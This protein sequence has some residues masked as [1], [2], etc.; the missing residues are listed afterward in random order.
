LL[1]KR[2][3]ALLKRRAQA[4][5]FDAAGM[6]DLLDQ[7]ER[8]ALEDH[9]GFRGQWD[10]HRRFQIEQLRRLGLQTECSL[11]EIGCGPLTAGIPIIEYL[12]ANNY[13]GIDVRSAVLDLSWQ[14]VGRSSLSD[15]NPRLIRSDD[16]GRTELGDD[17][18]DFVWSFSVLYHLSDE[19]LD[20]LFCQ[21]ARRLRPEGQF[22]ANV[23]TDMENSTWLE[24][25]FLKRSVDFYRSAAGKYKLRTVNLGS[26]AE[27]GFRL[28]SEERNNPLLQFKLG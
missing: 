8:H 18:F 2:T 11:L 5:L 26:L 3:R 7:R 19:I 17:K 24:F 4:W 10:E 27:L 13:V 6:Q 28:P 25:P 20:Q 23:M 22:V 21:V 16:F 15:K 9:M 1:L 12:K 14:Q